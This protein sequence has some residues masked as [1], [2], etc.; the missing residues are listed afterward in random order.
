MLREICF[1]AQEVLLRER[2]CLGIPSLVISVADNQL[3]ICKNLSNENYIKFIGK[4]YEIDSKIISNV[5]FESINNKIEINNKNDLVD[6]YGVKRV[7]NQLLG[8]K[9]PVHLENNNNLIE[10]RDDCIIEKIIKLRIIFI[11]K[12]IIFRIMV[13]WTSLRLRS[14]LF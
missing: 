11:S 3:E 8:I 12:R 10:N 14:I 6:G 4:D 7:V 13:I 2:L 9:F 1:L 5:L